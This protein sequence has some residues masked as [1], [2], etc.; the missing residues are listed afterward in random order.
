VWACKWKLEEGA[1]GE[2]KSEKGRKSQKCVR[3]LLLRPKNDSMEKRA[4]GNKV[5]KFEKV[6]KVRKL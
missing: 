6:E 2:K 1:G 4:R 3:K 5:E